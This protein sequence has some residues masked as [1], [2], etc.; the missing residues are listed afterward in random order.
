M[1]KKS[2]PDPLQKTTCS[3]SL[4]NKYVYAKGYCLK[5]WT[6]VKRY[7]REHRIFQKPGSQQIRQGYLYTPVNGKRVAEHVIIAE[8]A[9]G[10]KLPKGA[11]VHHVDGNKLNNENN[12]LVICQSSAYHNLIH[13][14][15]RSFNDCGNPAWR[16]CMYCKNYDSPNNVTVTKHGHVYHKTCNTEHYRNYR[17]NRV[18]L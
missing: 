1:A 11:H 16:R 15:Q 7:N 12:N 10:R 6:R 13:L 17:K 18:S 2:L 3:I 5:H 9:L 14:R 8:K 4:C